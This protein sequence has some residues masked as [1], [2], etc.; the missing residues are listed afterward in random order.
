[1]AKKGLMSEEFDEMAADFDEMDADG[2]GYLEMEEIVK[3][4]MKQTGVSEE[5]AKGHA[6]SQLAMMDVDGDGKITFNEYLDALC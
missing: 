6:T 3:I 1:M 4:V 2:S 5:E